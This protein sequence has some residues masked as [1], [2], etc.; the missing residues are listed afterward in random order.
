MA[1]SSNTLVLPLCLLALSLAAS[2]ASA[3]SR[4]F[5]YAYETAVLNPG[6]LDLE[7]W[8][9]ARIGRDQY[10]QRY[11]HR[12]ELET[13]V[14]KN[15]Q[16]AWYLNLSTT[17]ADTAAGRETS[18]SLQGFSTEWK[19]K[20]SD[21]VADAVGSA[22]YLEGSFGPQEV[23]IEAKLIFDKRWGNFLLAFNA[24]GELELELERQETEEEIVVE[25]DLGLAY[26]VG[27]H[28]SFGVEVRSHNEFKEGKLEHGAIFA[29]PVMSYAQDKWWMALSALPQVVGFGEGADGLDLVGHTKLETR[30]LLGFEL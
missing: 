1:R 20:L 29:G 12:L 14:V 3:S 4:R 2:T 8:T 7:P 22:L 18:S 26:L 5:T 25:G 16:M 27:Q 24:V 15:L 6:D 30:L 17:A 28:F 10:F 11:D 23:E 19:Y 21:P 9:T 13:G